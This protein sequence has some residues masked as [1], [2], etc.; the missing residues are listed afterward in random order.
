MAAEGRTQRASRLPAMLLAALGLVAAPAAA[1]F[2]Y[3]P[4]AGERAAFADALDRVL[5]PDARAFLPAGSAPG[6]VPL[7]SG[8]AS[9]WRARLE[10]LA[11]AAALECATEARP[12]RE[13]EVRLWPRGT[14]RDAHRFEPVREPRRWT[15]EPGD[16]LRET[17]TRWAAEAGTELEWLAPVDWRLRD[18][19]RLGGEWR[20]AARTLLDALR[21]TIPA[22]AGTF[23]GDGAELAIRAIPDVRDDG[24]GDAE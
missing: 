24:A 16:T 6:P 14:A 21:H 3:A 11:W 5:P 10:E 23:F 15:A 4:P 17:L 2:D 13:V 19:V 7:P 20:W 22:P 12:G 8:D 18:P 9:A 1:G